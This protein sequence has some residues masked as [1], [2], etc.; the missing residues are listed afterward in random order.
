M[1]LP[2]LSCTHFSYPTACGHDGYFISADS[3]ISKGSIDQQYRES[4]QHN[5][6]A[7]VPWDL[8]QVTLKFLGTS[9]RIA[10]NCHS[11]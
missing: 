9:F 7:M 1:H 11:L 3:I 10:E 5:Q 8:S 6:E 2:C 4:T